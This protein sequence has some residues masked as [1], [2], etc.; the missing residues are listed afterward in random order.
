MNFA[1]KTT[2]YL[3]LFQQ[4]KRSRFQDKL[5]LATFLIENMAKNKYIFDFT[6][7]IIKRINKL[8]FRRVVLSIIFISKEKLW[9]HLCSFMLR[10]TAQESFYSVLM[11][12]PV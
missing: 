9:S 12:H 1:Y 5:R 8:I 11:S 6:T 10:N 4:L 3:E 2:M 7:K